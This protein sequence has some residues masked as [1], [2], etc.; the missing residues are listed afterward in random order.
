[1][2]I[3]HLVQ[4]PSTFFRKPISWIVFISDGG[5]ISTFIISLACTNE[6]STVAVG[7]INCSLGCPVKLYPTLVGVN[8]HTIEFFDHL[9]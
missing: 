5:I 3:V 2:A 1:M 9:T 6:K 8:R 4:V 7:R